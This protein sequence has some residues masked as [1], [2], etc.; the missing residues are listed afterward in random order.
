MPR[1]RRCESDE[2]TV[3]ASDARADERKREART[4]FRVALA[5]DVG[6]CR[7]W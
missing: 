5:F 2:G 7:V 6:L 3:H 4:F 1:L